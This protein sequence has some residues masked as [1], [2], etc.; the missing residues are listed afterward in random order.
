MDFVMGRLVSCGGSNWVNCHRGC[1]NAFTAL[2]NRVNR[3]RT[4]SS[5]PPGVNRL[6]LPTYVRL[7]ASRQQQPLSSLDGGALAE[8]LALLGRWPHC[9]RSHVQYCSE[10]SPVDTD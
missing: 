8:W 1:T 4:M 9:R 10:S 7:P 3:R 6:H 5:Q 2:G